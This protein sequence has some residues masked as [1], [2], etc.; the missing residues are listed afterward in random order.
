[1][2]PRAPWLAMT[3]EETLPPPDPLGSALP[4]SQQPALSSPSSKIIAIAL[5]PRARKDAFVI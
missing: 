4:A 5:L 1:M 3:I 2:I